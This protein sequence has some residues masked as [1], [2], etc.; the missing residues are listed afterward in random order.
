MNKK[1]FIAA[2]AEETNYEKKVVEEIING[3]LSVIES[4]VERNEPIQLTGYFNIITRFKDAKPESL[5][6]NP[7]DPTGEK[8]VRKAQ[9]EKMIPA[10]K[11]GKKLKDAA[12]KAPVVK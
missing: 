10:I 11:I 7:Q 5:G 2:T 3:E 12:L 8:I 4:C 6:V 1:E 9:P